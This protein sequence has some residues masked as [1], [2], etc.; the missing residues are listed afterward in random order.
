[1]SLCS[2]GYCLESGWGRVFVGKIHLQQRKYHGKCLKIVIFL[3]GVQ[4]R[5]RH[6]QQSRIKLRPRAILTPCVP[7]FIGEL[8][9]PTQIK[10]R[11]YRPFK[12]AFGDVSSVDSLFFI[13]PPGGPSRGGL[14]AGSCGELFA[15]GGILQVPPLPIL[16]CYCTKSA[17]CGTKY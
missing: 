9:I 12:S 2:G 15:S 1:M 6:W 13:W 17:D 7:L 3:Q 10:W 11:L 16:M 5:L 8:L 14:P 4:Y